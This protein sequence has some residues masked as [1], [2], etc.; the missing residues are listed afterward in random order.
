MHSGVG[1]NVLQKSDTQ[2]HHPADLDPERRHY[3]I[4]CLFSVK[5]SRIRE[6]VLANLSK[7]LHSQNLQYDYSKH[8]FQEFFSARLTNSSE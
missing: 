3:I 8:R 5:A 1:I 2:A 6:H 7:D 4:V